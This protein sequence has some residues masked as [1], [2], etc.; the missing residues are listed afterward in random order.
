MLVFPQVTD[1]YE[2]NDDNQE[3]EALREV[4]VTKLRYNISIVINVNTKAESIEY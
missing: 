1:L 2:N 3:G 4:K